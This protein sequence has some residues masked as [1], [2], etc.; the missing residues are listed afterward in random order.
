M[1]N[2]ISPLILVTGA[3]GQ[4][5]RELKILSFNYPEFQFTFLSKEELAINNPESLTNLF[6]N[7]HPGY[8][9]NCAAYTA[10]DKAEEEK[11]IAFLVNAKAVG[12]LSKVCKENNTQL[13]HIS[14]DY[15]FDGTSFIPYKEEDATNPQNVYGYSKLEGEKQALLSNPSS[16]IIRTSWVYSEFGKNFVKTILKLLHEKEEVNVVN[17]QVGS[18]TYAYDLAKAIL[19]IISQLAIKDSQSSSAAGIYHFTNNGAITWYDFAIAIKELSGS[20]CKINPV[21]SDRFPTIARRPA[22]SVLNK[23][24]IQQTFGIN[25][26]DWKESLAVCFQKIKKNT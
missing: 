3:N 26:K 23:A 13:I 15:V 24:K 16:I 9:I 19:Q 2:N 11:D 22:Y 14:T 25:L 6:A 4:L 8:C 21:S 12:I 1:E 10:V 17:D 20:S 7:I 5:G 18:P